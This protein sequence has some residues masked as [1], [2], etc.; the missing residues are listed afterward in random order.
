MLDPP[1]AAALAGPVLE[2][3][4]RDGVMAAGGFCYVELPA[5]QPVPLPDGWTLHRTGKA[6]EVGYHLLHAPSRNLPRDV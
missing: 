6:G 2:Q 3:L 1:F 5:A 4:A